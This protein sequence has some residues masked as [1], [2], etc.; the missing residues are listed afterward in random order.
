[1]LSYLRNSPTCDLKNAI[2][3]DHSFGV[4]F[5]KSKNWA[6]SWQ[7]CSMRFFFKKQNQK[8]VRCVTSVWTSSGPFCPSDFEKIGLALIQLDIDWESVPSSLTKFPGIWGQWGLQRYTEEKN[9]FLR[10]LLR[11]NLAK[12]NKQINKNRFIRNTWQFRI[13]KIRRVLLFQPAL[14]TGI[15]AQN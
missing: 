3:K 9:I 14:V 1:M 15:S 12:T 11:L 8:S 7:M 5:Q 4:I 13:S 2:T 10:Y 6:F